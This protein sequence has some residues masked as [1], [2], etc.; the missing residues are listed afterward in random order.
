[1]GDRAKEMLQ[2]RLVEISTANLAMGKLMTVTIDG[3][4]GA[5]VEHDASLKKPEAKEPRFGLWDG[6]PIDPGRLIVNTLLSNNFLPLGT[7]N[8]KQRPKRKK[9]RRLRNPAAR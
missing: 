2:L 9:R 3:N 6:Q 5:V 7:S 1:V 4:T 8:P